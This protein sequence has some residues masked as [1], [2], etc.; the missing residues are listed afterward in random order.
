MNTLYGI[1]NDT[2]FQ[3]ESTVRYYQN[4]VVVY[5]CPTEWSPPISPAPIFIPVPYPDPPKA[6]EPLWPLPYPDPPYRIGGLIKTVRERLVQAMADRDALNAEI[7]TMEKM[8]AIAE[9]R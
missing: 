9:G 6:N 2:G 7:E 3:N 1:P 5:G 8:L 4:E